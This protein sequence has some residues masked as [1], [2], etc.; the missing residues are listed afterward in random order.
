MANQPPK[1]LTQRL[2]QASLA[3]AGGAVLSLGFL[4]PA[5][6]AAGLSFSSSGVIRDRLEIQQQRVIANA[7]TSYLIPLETSSYFISDTTPPAPGRRVILRNVT[8]GFSNEPFS[9]RAYD[10]DLGSEVIL[11]R[12]GQGHE[13]QTFTVL[14]GSLTEPQ[15]NTFRYEIREHGGT[16]LESGDFLLTIGISDRPLSTLYRQQSGLYPNPRYVT[17]YYDEYDSYGYGGYNGRQRSIYPRSHFRRQLQE[18]R[19]RHHRR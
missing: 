11:L 12:P 14:P 17:N 9:D 6:A 19:D 5:N 7:W 3:L 10:N 4:Q 1:P 2:S 8:P 15:Q 13:T 16:V 18:Y